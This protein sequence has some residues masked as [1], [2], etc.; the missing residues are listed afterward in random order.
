M[1]KAKNVA[2]L[3]DTAR[4]Y[5]CEMIRGIVKYSQ[6]VGHWKFFVDPF[7]AAAPGQRVLHQDCDGMIVY[8]WALAESL[9]RSPVP[10]VFCCSGLSDLGLPQV[11]PDNIAI[12]RMAAEHLLQCGFR[13]FGFWPGKTNQTALFRGKGFTE[14]LAEAGYACNTCTT[15]QSGA[16]GQEWESEREGLQHWI[17]SLPRPIGVLTINDILCRRLSVV[18]QDAGLRIPEDIS[19]VGVDNEELICEFSEPPL[20][21]VDPS[22][23]QVGYEA[24]SLLGRIMDCQ[25]P[26]KKPILVPPFGLVARQSTNTLVVDDPL[27]ANAVEFIRSH[28]SKSVRIGD[29]LR[30]VGASRR[31]L[32]MRFKASIGRGPVSEIR[33]TR[34]EQAKKLLAETHESI[35]SIAHLAGFSNAQSLCVIFRREVGM[36]PTGYRKQFREGRRLKED[37]VHFSK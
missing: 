18:C 2:V 15:I 35:A 4:P 28:V 14:R 7:A 27:V 5:R 25:A 37:F 3:V 16:S 26:P 17:S 32:E 11:L 8:T 33:R 6:Q 13:N 21:S 31:S 19:L 22:W 24:A 20:S 23:G 9:V 12:G 10:V 34:I 29:L 1:A 30:L 36:P